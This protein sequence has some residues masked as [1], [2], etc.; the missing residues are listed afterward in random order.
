MAYL[1]GFSTTFFVWSSKTQAEN[2]SFNNNTLV[3]GINI[4]TLNIMYVIAMK[5]QRTVTIDHEVDEELRQRTHINVSALINEL[6]KNY[7]EENKT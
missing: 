6:L 3:K 7:L 1:M 5:A 4:Y 2:V